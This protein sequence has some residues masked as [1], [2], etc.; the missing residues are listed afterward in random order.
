VP[1]RPPLIGPNE[2][3][4][5]RQHIALLQSNPDRLNAEYHIREI[6]LRWQQE[7]YLRSKYDEFEWHARNSPHR[8]HESF[9]EWVAECRGDWGDTQK[10]IP[11]DFSEWMHLDK[12]LPRIRTEN[13]P[14]LSIEDANSLN[15]ERHVIEYSAIGLIALFAVAFI[16]EL[17][18]GETFLAFLAV[19]CVASTG[20]GLYTA[21]QNKQKLADEKRLPLPSHIYNREYT[22]PLADNSVVR[23]NIFFTLPAAFSNR[24]QQLDTFTEKEFLIF[25]ATKTVPPTAAE[26]QDHLAKRLRPFQDENQIPFLRVEVSLHIHIAAPKP[27]GGG[28]VS[29]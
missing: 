21:N 26:I 12:N 14:K 16:I 11:P 10:P 3:E 28:V 4:L 29:V 6:T 22:A 1:L 19:I 23:T 2:P 5:R 27:K 8:A 17:V 7:D 13:P 25:V 9:N 18:A 15:G 24:D 20:W